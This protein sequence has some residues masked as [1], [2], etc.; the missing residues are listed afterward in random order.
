MSLARIRSVHEAWK[1]ISDDVA[2]RPTSSAFVWGGRLSPIPLVAFYGIHYLRL[3]SPL[4]WIKFVTRRRIA[5][6]PTTNLRPDFPSAFTEWYFLCVLALSII[7]YVQRAHLAQAGD[8][9]GFVLLLVEWVLLVETNVW[10]VYYLLLR[11]FLETRYTIFHPAEYLLTFPVVI[12]IVGLLGALITGRDLNVLLVEAV[13]N[14][15]KGDS[16]G[17]GVAV[18]AL[19]YFGVAITVVLSSHPG[20]KTRTPQTLVI[21][22]AGDVTINRTLPGLLALGYS[23][24]DIMVVT[25]DEASEGD[26]ATIAKRAA[27][28]L[29]TAPEQVMQTSLRGGAPTIIASPTFAHFRQLVQLASA[30]MRFAVEKPI[31]SSRS[32]RDI[33]RSEPGLMS[34]GFALSYYTL[35][36]ALPLTYI[37]NPLP[38][39]R[40]FLASEPASLLDSAE[41]TSL[42]ERL[43]PLV[44]VDVELLEGVTRSPRGEKR[45]WTELPGTLRPFVETT[46]HPLL[47]IRHVTGAAKPEWTRCLIGRYTPRAE[48]IRAAVGQEIAPTWIVA[49]GHINRARI[50]V[51]VGKYVPE[52]QTRRKAVFDYARG[53]IECDFDERSARILLGDVDHGKVRID[54]ESAGGRFKTNYAVLMS[55]FMEFSLNGW[56]AVRFD[57]F[58]RQL[59][60]LDWWDNLCDL[61]EDAEVPVHP[62]EHQPPDAQPTPLPSRDSENC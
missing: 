23:R 35:E 56:G 43:G 50:R 27:R 45:L 13:G 10:I 41:L 18:A 49:E 3:A 29:V 6:R 30:D 25:V 12:A 52:E 44:S 7:A 47:V 1:R 40:R 48:E 22:G 51:N 55:L 20:I 39:Y 28:L 19:F 9:A 14:P 21:V 37:M 54:V 53:R 59:D 16:I 33:L 5:A 32:E 24:D 26:R 36:K 46:V 62:Y 11:G 15:E 58:T 60:A 61:V 38:V 2:T 17:V 57:D 31:V 42:K 4:Q 34:N 8:V